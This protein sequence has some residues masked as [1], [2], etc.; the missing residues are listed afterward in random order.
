MTAKEQLIREIEQTPENLIEELLEI[1][2][3]MSLKI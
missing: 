1:N 2:K 3:L